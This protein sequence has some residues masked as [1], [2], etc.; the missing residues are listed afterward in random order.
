MEVARG[1]CS[2]GVIGSNVF[3]AGGGNATE[4]LSNCLTWTC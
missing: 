3:V 4:W 2:S 1:Y